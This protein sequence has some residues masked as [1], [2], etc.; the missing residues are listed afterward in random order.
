M[1]SIP[2]FVGLLLLA[3]CGARTPPAD[4]NQAAATQ[5]EHPATTPARSAVTGPVGPSGLRT[6]Y[7]QCVDA[8]AGVVPDTQQCIGDEFEYQQQRLAAVLK[9]RLGEPGSST[10]AA[11]QAAWRTATDTR[12]AWNA[13][14]EGQGQRL[15]ANACELEAIAARADQLSR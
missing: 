8:A 15:E 4:E 3:G 11:E 9:R 6:Q 1:K 13:E 12:C 7:Q 5:R 10:T 14:E 2:V